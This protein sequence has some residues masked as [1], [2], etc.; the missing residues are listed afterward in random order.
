MIGP[1]VG[2][3]VPIIRTYE[4]LM[5]EE[6]YNPIKFEECSQWSLAEKN[7][8]RGLCNYVYVNQN[9]EILVEDL[10]Q[11][12]AQITLMREDALRQILPGLVRYPILSGGRIRGLAFKV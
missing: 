6:K 1:Q 9:G 7:A 5:S 11:K 3:P 10:I 8:V 2:A 12:I 4:Q